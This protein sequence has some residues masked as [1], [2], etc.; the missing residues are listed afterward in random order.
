MKL[1]KWLV[2]I[3]KQLFTKENICE[4]A[5]L[6][7]LSKRVSPKDAE[8]IRQAIVVIKSVGIDEAIK[9]EARRQLRKLLKNE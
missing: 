4:A 8:M 7:L 3:T 1:W 9:K 2:K 6:Y 5:E